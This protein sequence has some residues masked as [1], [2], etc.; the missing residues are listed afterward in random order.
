MIVHNEMPV[1]LAADGRICFH[2]YR[3]VTPPVVVWMGSTAEIVMH[4]ECVVELAI[5][6]FRDVHEIEQS[7]Q[8]YVT[9]PRSVEEWRRQ[10]VASEHST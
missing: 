6:L 5:R 3:D 2:C 10:L 4:P 1:H 7:T 9:G 8:R